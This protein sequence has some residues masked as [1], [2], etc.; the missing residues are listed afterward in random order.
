M[1]R[2]VHIA[3]ADWLSGLR[4]YRRPLQSLVAVVA[5][6]FLARVLLDSWSQVQPQMIHVE[7]LTLAISLLPLVLTLLYDVLPWRTALRALGAPLT[8]GAAARI[9]FLSNIVRYIPGNVWQPATMV[10]LART[11]GVSE[12]RTGMSVALN[13]VLSNLSALLVAGALS[14][15][16]PSSPL[17]ERVWLLILLLTLALVCLHPALL[18]RVLR[19]LARRAARDDSLPLWRFDQLIILLAL[20]ALTWMGYGVAFAIFWSAFAPVRDAVQLTAAFAAA[21]AIGF[22]S[23]LTP[24]GLGVRE[25]A[26]VF[27][28]SGSYPAALVALMALLSRVWLIG[29]ELL[30]T[31]IV[32]AFTRGRDA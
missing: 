20:Y 29:G 3:A 4:R 14:L 25:G 23:L 15:A 10:A 11:R 7:P 13:W 22:L 32:L 2:S 8:F 27:L 18:S 21:Y 28:L 1:P 12:L 17:H 19:L 24:S 26:L 6:G 5:L 30:C 16:E 31:G 9:W